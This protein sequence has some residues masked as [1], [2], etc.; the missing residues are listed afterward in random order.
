MLIYTYYGGIFAY[1]KARWDALKPLTKLLNIPW[2]LRTG[3]NFHGF[4]II[5]TV[6]YLF[7]VLL[8]YSC[9][10]S[11]KCKYNVKICTIF[12]G[13][14]IYVYIILYIY[15]YARSMAF[16][17]IRRNKLRSVENITRCSL[18]G[19]EYWPLYV[20]NEK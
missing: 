20:F 15:R 19:I 5:T 16:E 9:V 7:S 12:H 13:K 14:I 1:C 10:V 6:I 11:A 17:I 3:E 4:R 8:V 18:T 2:K